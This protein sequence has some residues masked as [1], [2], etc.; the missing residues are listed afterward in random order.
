MAATEEALPKDEIAAP[1]KK[2]KKALIAGIIAGVLVLEGVGV[3]VVAKM[4]NRGPASAV[5][6]EILDNHTDKEGPE[7]PTEQM[8]EVVIVNQFEC[9]HSN[10]GRDYAIHMTVYALVPKSLAGGEEGEKKEEKEKKKEGAEPTG[11][12]AE[13]EKHI[14]RIRDRFRT[15][16][17]GADAGTLCLTKS[18]KPDNGLSTLRRQFKTILDEILGK[19][20][21]KDVL[22]TDYMY[23]PM[24]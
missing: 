17:A 14:A 24:D 1:A 18:E 12:A 20:K 3:F 2:P 13:V 23:T 11:F 22:I 7:H 5:A 8:D 21:V 19:N 10:S 6:G 4:L 16:I 9:P 15:V